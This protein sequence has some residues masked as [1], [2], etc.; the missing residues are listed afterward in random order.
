MVD[1]L[2]VESETGHV[3]LTIADSWSWTDELGHLSALQEKLN[4]YFKYIESGQVWEE[5]TAGKG[6]QLRI[7][8]VFRFAP[9]AAAAELL[10]KAADVASQ[11]DILVSYDT[12][13]GTGSEV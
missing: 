5:C 1:A 7:N 4:A 2:G 9:P 8:V 10:A 11:L 6:R 12:F 3:V 13:A